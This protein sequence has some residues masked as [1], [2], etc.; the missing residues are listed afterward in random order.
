MARIKYQ[1]AA[2][3]ELKESRPSIWRGRFIRAGIP[4]PRHLILDEGQDLNEL[5]N[6]TRSR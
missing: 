5:Y 4:E 2:G 6:L 1:E 3:R